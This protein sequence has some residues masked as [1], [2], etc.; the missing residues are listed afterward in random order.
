[1]SNAIRAVPNYVDLWVGVIIDNG[2]SLVVGLWDAELLCWIG[3]LRVHSNHEGLYI[4]QNMPI[5]DKV[6]GIALL[7]LLWIIG[8]F[9]RH[10]CSEEKSRSDPY[11][12]SL[13]VR[14]SNCDNA[15]EIALGEEVPFDLSLLDLDLRYS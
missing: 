3:S 4:S 12:F 10:E 15:V 1:M 5:C 2:P 8:I 9:N 14:G 11:D 13:L 6:N 7:F